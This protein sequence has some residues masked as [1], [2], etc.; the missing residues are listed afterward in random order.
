MSTAAYL[1]TNATLR[2]ADAAELL[3]DHS[4]IVCTPDIDIEKLREI[5]PDAHLLA[6]YLPTVCP[7][8]GPEADA[9]RD[10]DGRERRRAI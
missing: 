6:Y 3:S 8:Y 5:N 1:C 10:D 2:R 7:A 4:L 9:A